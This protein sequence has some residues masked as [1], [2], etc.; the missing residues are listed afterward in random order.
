MQGY[1][2]MSIRSGFRHQTLFDRLATAFFFIALPAAVFVVG[3]YGLVEPGPED[4]R[5]LP[6]VFALGGIW[7]AL[8]FLETRPVTVALGPDGV[9]RTDVWSVRRVPYPNVARLC[10]VREHGRLRIAVRSRAGSLLTLNDE[11]DEEDK[12]RFLEA[13]AHAVAPHGVVAET[14]LA[15]LW[16]MFGYVNGDSIRRAGERMWRAPARAL[17]LLGATALSFVLV[18]AGAVAF[19]RGEGIVA[20]VL[21]PLLLVLVL[22][23]AGVIARRDVL[24]PIGCLVLG[25]LLLSLLMYPLIAPPFWTGPGP[26]T[27]PAAPWWAMFSGGALCLGVGYELLRE[28]RAGRPTGTR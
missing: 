5:D 18:L 7:T 15:A 14:S 8:A 13:L 23:T 1:G 3:L 28:A 9:T 11:F 12:A 16:S 24:V 6:A 20:F 27:L 26:Q 10:G 17:L 21:P 4:P 25:G 2:S 19:E 22:L